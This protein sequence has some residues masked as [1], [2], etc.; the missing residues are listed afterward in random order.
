MT[1]AETAQSLG[2]MGE[3]LGAIAVV[4]TLV[5]L[6]IHVRQGRLATEANTRSLNLE[7]QVVVQSIWAGSND[8][9]EPVKQCSL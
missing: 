1:F 7:A 9:D 4:V 8:E 2:N 5:Y 3:F 6:T